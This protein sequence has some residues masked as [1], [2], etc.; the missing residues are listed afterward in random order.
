MATDPTAIQANPSDLAIG[1][2]FGGSG[3]KGAVVD[4]RTGSLVGDRLRVPTPQPSVPREVV[5]VMDGLIRRLVEPWAPGEADGFP[6]GVGIPAAIRNGTTMT[7]ANI[8]S[9][10]KGFPAEREMSIVLK[11]TVAVGNDA[12]VAGLAELRFGA[13]RG[14][15]GLV[16]VLTIGTGVGSALFIDGHLVPNTEIGHLEMRG[17]DAEERVA[18][19]ARDRLGLNWRDW[20]AGFD[21]YLHLLER[22]FW[23]DLFILGG[24]ASKRADNYLPYVT[25]KTPIALATLRN[26]AGI[27]GGALIAHERRYHA[28]V[29]DSGEHMA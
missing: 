13:G 21:E 26:N 24:G 1:I 19:S 9:T 14:Q 6:V 5:A 3:I 4:V 12:D 11:R 17:R 8:D 20:A 23:P 16:I 27:V 18:E 7:A 25:A 2:D 29:R 15:S 28:A 10:W 22:L